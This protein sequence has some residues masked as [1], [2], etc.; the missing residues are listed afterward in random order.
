MNPMRDRS[1][2]L[3]KLSSNLPAEA[4]LLKRQRI[5][6]KLNTFLVQLV[7]SVPERVYHLELI[8]DKNEV[9]LSKPLVVKIL[10]DS[11]PNFGNVDIPHDDA[12]P[13]FNDFVDQRDYL[14][15]GVFGD[16]DS[17][18]LISILDID[19]PFLPSLLDVLTKRD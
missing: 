9:A 19:E 13:G 8:A 7:I 16:C 18:D 12:R 3:I 2:L 14:L 6:E 17:D 5:F 15:K 4:S 10:S 11:I 1:E